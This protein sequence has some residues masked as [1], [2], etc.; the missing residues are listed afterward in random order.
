VQ[1]LSTDSGLDDGDLDE[2]NVNFSENEARADPVIASS[3][4]FSNA[5]FR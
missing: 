3:P 5:E 2:S 1:I 4:A